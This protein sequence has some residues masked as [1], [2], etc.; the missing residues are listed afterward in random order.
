MLQEV[1]ATS[2]LDAPC[3]DLFWMRETVLPVERY[4]GMDIVPELIEDN[5]K[6]YGAEGREFRLGDLVS[7]A[8]P[9]V[10]VILCRDCL[11]HLPS[12]QVGEALRNFRRSGS[13]YLLTTTFTELPANEDIDQP[14]DWRPINLQRPPFNLPM[15]L[16]VLNEGC[17]ELD[18]QF[19]D[20]SLG[21]WRL[22]DLGF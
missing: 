16:R 15:P 10:D 17:T 18:G 3:G 12:R 6:R 9:Q 1:G 20:K 11:V 13:K 2:L 8:L 19:A 5:V 21:L 4:I 22:S 14:G 7:S